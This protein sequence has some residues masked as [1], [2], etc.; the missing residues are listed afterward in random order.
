MNR[1]D[2]LGPDALRGFQGLDIHL[3]IEDDSSDVHFWEKLK[4]DLE[5]VENCS[6]RMGAGS[7][8][9]STPRSERQYHGEEL[10]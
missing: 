2:T 5:G 1:Q 7:R 4:I 10:N 9:P 6:L 8:H 3:P